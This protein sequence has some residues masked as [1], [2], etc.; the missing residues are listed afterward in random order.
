MKGS[1]NPFVKKTNT[2]L[3]ILCL[4]ALAILWSGTAKADPRKINWIQLDYQPFWILEGPDEGQGVVD[5]IMDE[6]I[7]ELP[8]YKHNLVLMNVRRGIEKLRDGEQYCFTGMIYRPDRVKEFAMSE[9]YSVST[10]NGVLVLQDDEEKFTPFITERGTFDLKK[11]LTEEGFLL[12]ISRARSYGTKLDAFFAQYDKDHIYASS[13]DDWQI[14]MLEMLKRKRLSAFVGIGFNTRYY[15]H[16]QPDA[17]QVSWYP[18]D[19]AEGG[20]TAHFAC[21]KTDWGRG[22]IERLN[23]IILTRRNRPEF[24]KY[25][26]DWV[27]ENTKAYH[28]QLMTKHFTPKSG[29]V[30]EQFVID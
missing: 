12:G 22:V 15:R 8:E 2:V 1:L 16:F 17:P 7:P 23:P 11:A 25:L 13:G 30:L 9:P 6:L 3:A 21:P 4:L 28:K 26:F 27:P 5:K 20:M 14:R 24:Y 29:P 19:G 10:L 18:I